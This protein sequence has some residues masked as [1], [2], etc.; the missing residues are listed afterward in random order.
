MSNE[1]PLDAIRRS[2][3]TSKSRVSAKPIDSAEETY[4]GASIETKPPTEEEPLNETPADLP[5]AGEAPPVATE[6]PVAAPSAPALM[7]TAPRRRKKGSRAVPAK[8]I[9]TAAFAEFASKVGKSDK[10]EEPEVSKEPE[11][12][13]KSPSPI[14]E[15]PVAKPGLNLAS[16]PS[17]TPP[18]PKLSPL[19]SPVPSPIKTASPAKEPSPVIAA[20]SPAK[21]SP[22]KVSTPTEIPEEKP[23]TPE[24]EV[25]VIAPTTA[26]IQSDANRVSLLESELL[27]VKNQLSTKEQ[28]AADYTTLAEN[29]LEGGTEPTPENLSVFLLARLERAKQCDNLEAEHET[30][31]RELEETKATSAD[32]TPDEQASFIDDLNKKFEAIAQEKDA[33]TE[34]LSQLQQ[35]LQDRDHEIEMLANK[36]EDMPG[37]IKVA[38]LEQLNEEMQARFKETADFIKEMEDF[39]NE[40]QQDL[41]EDTGQDDTKAVM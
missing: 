6:P 5:A 4:M 33:I 31:K 3:S 26:I 28:L 2:I 24:K 41:V 17:P 21:A 14:P 40:H 10:P 34:Q 11:V 36:M 32:R 15:E 16:S 12:P 30:L 29:V 13:P 18:S 19:P 1:D 39:L 22:V 23:P 27:D 37:E 38:S 25:V 8:E 20:P 9:D 7:G 35:K